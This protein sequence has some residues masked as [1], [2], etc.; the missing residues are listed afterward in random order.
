MQIDNKADAA[1]EPS[2][3]LILVRHGETEANVQQRWYGAM[4][5]PLTERG[6]RQVAA[7][8]AAMV[9][10]NQDLPIDVFYVSPLPR[11]RA[12]AGAIAD[13]IELQP[14]IDEGLREFDLG[15]WE[16][17]TFED[18][19]ASE[20][21][22]GHWDA[23][24]TFAPPNGESP[25]SFSQRVERAVQSLVNRHPGQTILIV[26]HG[27][28]IGNLLTRWLGDSP[29]DW[30]RWDPPNCSITILEKAVTPSGAAWNPV[31]VN[32]VSHL[33]EDIRAGEQEETPA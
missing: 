33:P 20:D 1:L 11:A 17:R 15:D 7:T 3:T 24:P 8:A 21:L 2:T 14:Q 16:G 19:H 23:D 30:R 29:E 18:L 6:R 28:L 32:D 4:D 27:G 25:A 31:L 13:A 26:S 12:T 9:E 22:W 5:A 10:L